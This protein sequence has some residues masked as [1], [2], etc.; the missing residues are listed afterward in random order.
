MVVVCCSSPGSDPTGEPEK[1]G[2]GTATIEE[3]GSLF[4][5]SATEPGLIEFRTNDGAYITDRGYTLWALK[6]AAQNPFVSRTVVLNKTSGSPDAGYGIVFCHRQ[7]GSA[8]EETMLVAMIDTEQEYIVG[9][10]VGST[11][12][13]IVRWKWSEYLKKGYNQDNEIGIRLNAATKTFS[14]SVN[15][16]SVTTFTAK[17]TDYDLGGGNGFL[18]VVSPRDSFPGT[19]VSVTFR[20]K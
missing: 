1:P 11:F 6:A 19:P 10:A 17:E 4:T 7:A 3:A 14:L 16:Q 5:S 8:A 18:A 12:T 13:E 15:G 2:G 20:E 9:E